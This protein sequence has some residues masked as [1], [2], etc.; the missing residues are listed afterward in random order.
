M[1]KVWDALA[2]AGMPFL[3][4]HDELI[5]QKE[6]ANEAYNLF[7]EVMGKEFT[8]FKINGKLPEKVN[9]SKPDSEILSTTII[10]PGEAIPI[11]PALEWDLNFNFKNIPNKP[12]RLSPSVLIS[13]P[14][15][16]I[17]SHLQTCQN[18]K[19]NRMRIPEHLD[20]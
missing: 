6:R 19:G 15:E 3:T 20:Q 7:S 9:Y 16:F 2:N 14:A 11:I 12:I 5:V 1:R 18:N 17:Y 13:N 8:Y 10:D 4:V